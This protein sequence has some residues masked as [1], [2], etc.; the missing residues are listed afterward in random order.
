MRTSLSSVCSE[1][2]FQS[3]H[4]WQENTSSQRIEHTFQHRPMASK[5]TNTS[6]TSY[7][8]L[9]DCNESHDHSLSNASVVLW[10]I[11]SNGAVSPFQDRHYHL[12]TVPEWPEGQ[13]HVD[14]SGRSASATS[15]SYMDHSS[16]TR[17]YPS[18]DF[19]PMLANSTI[20]PHD[21]YRCNSPLAEPHPYSNDLTTHVSQTVYHSTESNALITQDHLQYF[22]HPQ[23]VR[24]Y[25][26]TPLDD[27]IAEEDVEEEGEKPEPYAKLIFRCLRDAPSHE[28]FLRE[29]YDWFRQNT[30]KGKNPHE[31]GWQNSVRHNLSMNKVFAHSFLLY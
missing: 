25:R 15:T 23:D 11:N 31:K 2:K 8:G 22:N 7:H 19:S 10:P 18:M 27:N 24:S 13:F 26:G 30:D 20:A 28:L 4:L 12:E 17:T 5:S 16:W 3:Q 1:L 29:I 21:L 6:T 14:T 9:P